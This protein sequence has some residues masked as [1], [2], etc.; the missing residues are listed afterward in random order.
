MTTFLLVVI[1]CRAK[2]FKASDLGL[3]II[4]LKIEVH[5]FLRRLHVTS[6][7]EEYPNRGVGQ[8]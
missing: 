4:S 8:S 6:E 3:N 7:L 5:S 2:R 1:P